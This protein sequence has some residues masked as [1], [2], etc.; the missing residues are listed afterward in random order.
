MVLSLISETTGCK[1]YGE[2][3]LFTTCICFRYQDIISK[4]MHC[5]W[6]A[7]SKSLSVL[8]ERYHIDNLDLQTVSEVCAIHQLDS[9]PSTCQSQ[10]GTKKIYPRAPTVRIFK[11]GVGYYKIMHHTEVYFDKFNQSHNEIYQQEQGR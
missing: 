2:A 10:S 7:G 5:N 3:S 1:T 11:P 4:Q 8:C 9:L 6:L